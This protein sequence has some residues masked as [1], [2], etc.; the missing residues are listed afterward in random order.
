MG[1]STVEFRR[2]GKLQTTEIR[3]EFKDKQAE[4]KHEY[5]HGGRP[6]SFYGARSPSTKYLGQIYSPLKA[7]RIIDKTSNYES[8]VIYTI[9]HNAFKEI[10]KKHFSKID[11]I[12]EQI[13]TL[14]TQLIKSSDLAKFNLGKK[15]KETFF[16][17]PCC[18]S[19]INASAMSQ[20]GY[21][22]LKSCPICQSTVN[23]TFEN[24]WR[25]KNLGKSY[26]KI[27]AKID[28]KILT[29]QSKIEE[30]EKSMPETIDESK[31]N[32]EQKSEIFT[33][34]FADVHH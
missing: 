10:N 33:L 30:M 34:F 9:S 28:L 7:S 13:K 20:S 11:K 24:L 32:K 4:D 17:T 5:G 8:Y 15:E 1:H 6:D 31:I 21:P 2:K 27:K 22:T 25:E 29:L 18:K 14:N 16:N 12:K 3:K 23:N 26:V 19:K